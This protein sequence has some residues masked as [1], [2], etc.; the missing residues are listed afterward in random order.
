VKSVMSDDV[1][2]LDPSIRNWVLIPIMIVMFFVSILRHYLTKLMHPPDKKQDLKLIREKQALTRSRRLRT[3]GNVLP[4]SAFYHRKAFFNHPES[5]VFAQEIT[6]APPVNPLMDSS[7][8]MEMMKRSM[9]MIVP[10]ILLMSWVTYFFSGFVLV[11]LPFALTQRFKGLLQRGVDLEGLDMSYVSSLSWYFLN[12]FGLRGVLN[13][14]LGENEADDAK[15]MQSQMSGEMEQA[16]GPPID[17]AKL[18]TSE[19]ESLELAQ[20]DFSLIEQSEQ[21]LLFVLSC[22]TWQRFVSRIVGGR[23]AETADD[24]SEG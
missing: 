11:K 21:R 16:G 17:M 14:V 2:V 6:S 15:I 22:L 8:A 19:K 23:F 3:N 9:L 12:V 5:G 10:Q 18:F 24:N 13:L 4:P 20:H 7:G 1:F